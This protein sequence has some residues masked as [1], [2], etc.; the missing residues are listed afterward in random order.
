MFFGRGEQGACRP[1]QF[2]FT[3]AVFDVVDGLVEVDGFAGVVEK[4]DLVVAGYEVAEAYA[5]EAYE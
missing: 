4:V 3:K 1:H 2:I 5:D